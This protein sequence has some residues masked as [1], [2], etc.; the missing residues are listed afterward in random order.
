MTKHEHELTRKEMKG[1][2]QF[3]VAFGRATTWVVSNEKRVALVAAGLV[4]VVAAGV[5]ASAWMGSS[6]KEAA[7][8]L[9]KALEDM[10]GVISS[11]PVS[12]LSTPTFKTVEEKQRAVLAASEEV[13]R[14]YPSSEAARTATLAAGQAHFK[15][16]E[17]DLAI[18][19]WE[20][21]LRSAKDGDSLRFAALDGIARAQEAKGALDQSAATFERLA[22]EAA[23]YRDRATLERARVLAKAGKAAEAKKILQAFP[24]DFK[25][26]QLRPEAQELLARLGGA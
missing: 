2:D 6:E 16:A 17:H 11:V 5:G 3:Q 24:T 19:S 20:E 15:L 4:A 23:F 7:A 13:R 22:S 9:Y 1:P 25:D 14:Q 18:A 26:S 8:L 10:E 21:Y 12:A